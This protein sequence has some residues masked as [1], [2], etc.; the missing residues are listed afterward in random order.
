MT[1]RRIW[2]FLACFCCLFVLLFVYLANYKFWYGAREVTFEKMWDVAN[3][4]HALD[5]FQVKYSNLDEVIAKSKEKG[6][7]EVQPPEYYKFDAWGNQMIMVEL[8]N[9]IEKKKTLYIISVGHR[10]SNGN[11][12]PI[13]MPIAEH[14]MN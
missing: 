5:S 13:C 6:F 8:Q 11:E 4:C 9:I 2:I 7:T 3:L 1:R 12:P 10:S 14:P